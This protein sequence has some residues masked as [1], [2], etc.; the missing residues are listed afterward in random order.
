MLFDSR[1]MTRLAAFRHDPIRQVIPQG[2]P[3]TRDWRR[4][5]AVVGFHRFQRFT[6]ALKRDIDVPVSATPAIIEGVGVVIATDDGYVRM[7][8]SDLSRYFWERRMSASIYASLVVHAEARRV[9]ACDT[10][11]LICAF[12]L[13]GRLVWSFKASGAIRATPALDHAS[14][15]LVTAV[16]GH[17]IVGLHLES[18]ARLFDVE[19]P[20][21]WHAAIGG[22][23]SDRNPYASPIIMAG[24]LS[25]FC[26]GDQVILIDGAGSVLW[27]H[28]R[29]SEISSSPVIDDTGRMLLVADRSGT[30]ALINLVDGRV[31]A[32]RKLG[33]AVT[34]SGAASGSVFAL[35][36]RS[37]AVWGLDQCTLDIAWQ[38]GYGA[39]YDHT[40]FTVTPKGDFACVAACGDIVCRDA[41]NGEFLWRSSQM[42]GLPDQNLRLDVTPVFAPGGEMYAAGYDGSFYRFA[43]PD[44]TDGL[45]DDRSK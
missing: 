29:P 35:G 45:C 37:G 44:M 19:A 40:S 28:S 20:R 41:A 4:E 15:L 30:V 43:F 3:A 36:V 31:S 23:A 27:R 38:D 22:L 24:G 18:G 21:P 25:A 16:F 26:S 12:D 14:G 34:A 5:P 6:P 32:E 13:R 33:D 11:G 8:A 7:F 10:A 2:G 39:P 9:I 1:K 17:R 42:L